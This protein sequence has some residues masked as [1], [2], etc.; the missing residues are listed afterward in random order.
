MSA[1]TVRVSN[2]ESRPVTF[3][4]NSGESFL[5]APLER[6]REVR[7]LEVDGNPTVE[8]LKGRRVLDVSDKPSPA[9]RKGKAKA[10][11]KNTSKT[12]TKTKAKSGSQPAAKRGSAG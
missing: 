12:K 4:G 1:K 3:R 10:T 11:K 8:K 6:D 9:A 5:L 2:L 7:L